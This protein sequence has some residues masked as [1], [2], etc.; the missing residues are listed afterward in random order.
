MAQAK[1]VLNHINKALDLATHDL[2]SKTYSST[3]SFYQ[4]DILFKALKLAE[5][6]CANSDMSINLCVNSKVKC[7]EEDQTKQCQLVLNT[8]TVVVNSQN[9]VSSSAKCLPNNVNPN[10]RDTAVL[11]NSDSVSFKCMYFEEQ[12]PAFYEC[13][14]QASQSSEYGSKQEAWQI[15]L[16]SNW[17][18]LAYMPEVPAKKVRIKLSYAPGWIVA[19]I[20]MFSKCSTDYAFN[21]FIREMDE[22]LDIMKAEDLARYG[23]PRK[24]QKQYLSKVHFSDKELAN[25]YSVW[26]TCC[27]AFNQ[28]SLDMNAGVVL[29]KDQFATKLMRLGSFSDATI[30][31]YL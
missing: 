16:I 15:A 9:L 2:E 22:S 5:V 25:A 27:D 4:T 7:S 24:L 18:K 3:T 8:S 14:V 13:L 28:A 31:K 30:K 23:V 1:S 6:V 10:E 20:L 21:G 26:S 12:I 29:S 19:F 17:F 11:N